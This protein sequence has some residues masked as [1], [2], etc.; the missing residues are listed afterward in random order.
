M[1]I[2]TVMGANGTENSHESMKIA[3]NSSQ[4]SQGVENS[5]QQSSGN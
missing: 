1:Q 5:N 3:D 4:Y 2:I